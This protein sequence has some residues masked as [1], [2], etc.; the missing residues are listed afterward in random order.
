MG[1]SY[2]G[3]LGLVAFLTAMAQSWIA[4]GGAENT[5]RH[6]WLSLLVF[7]PLGYCIGRLGEWIVEDSV[8]GQLAA[9]VGARSAAA[10]DARNELKK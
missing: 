1:R 6:A 9:Q 2:G 5:L 4:G 8:R 10:N 7:A 3:I